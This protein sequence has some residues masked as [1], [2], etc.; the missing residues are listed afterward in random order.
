MGLGDAKLFLMVGI[1]LGLKSI[2]LILASS[3]IFGA[4]VGSLIIYFYKKI[5]TFKYLM[6]VLLFLA[7]AL[8]PKFGSVFYNL[9]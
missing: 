6:D 1:W 5:K 9:I 2:Y 7:A 3:A 8:Y 4:I